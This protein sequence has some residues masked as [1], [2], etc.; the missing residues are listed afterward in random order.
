MSMPPSVLAMMIGREVARSSS[1]AQIK[2]LF[3]FGRG[4]DEHFADEAA[5]GSGLLGDEHLAEHRSWRSRKRRRR[6]CRVS[7]RL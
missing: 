3:D 5:I 6:S 1:T 7:R 4:G 2:F